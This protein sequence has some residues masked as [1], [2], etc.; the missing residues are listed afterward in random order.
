M[1]LVAHEPFEST[2]AA[3]LNE[4]DIFSDSITVESPAM[5]LR[6]AD[7][8]TGYE[9]REQICRLEEL[10]EAYKDGIIAARDN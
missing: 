10:L 5:R 9:I 6:V 4:T 3:I 8:D 1:R 2:E 7:T